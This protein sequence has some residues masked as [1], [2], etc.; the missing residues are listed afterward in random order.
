[1]RKGMCNSNYLEF[2]EFIRPDSAAFAVENN[3]R[4]AK[5]LALYEFAAQFARGAICLDLACGM[6]FGTR[7]LAEHA[8]FVLGV[9]IDRG[10]VAAA[11][12]RYGS[13]KCRFAV[14]DATLL[15]SAP[16]QFDVVVSV[17]T[18][19]HIP[20]ERTEVFLSELRRIM[21]PD[22]ALILATPNKTV[23]DLYTST[24]GHCNELDSAEMTSLLGGFFKKV[25]CWG[26]GM[27]YHSSASRTQK[28]IHADVL[29]IR[30]L[31][32]RW[33][34]NLMAHLFGLRYGRANAPK[35]ESD[36]V[37]LLRYWEVQ[38]LTTVQQKKALY[39]VYVCWYARESGVA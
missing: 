30:R 5:Q 39:L 21:K 2:I 18:L 26:Q 24:D 10:A 9:D 31:V 20:S 27:N 33:L 22:G 25:S 6:G 14:G 15:G 17:A 7:Y 35:H 3:H 37:K 12:R 29:G 4:Y 32:P 1:M 36:L 19:E 38:E 16:Q 28:A 11:S 13:S 23:W 34:K 8:E